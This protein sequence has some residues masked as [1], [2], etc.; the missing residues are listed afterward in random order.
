VTDAELLEHI[1]RLPHARANFKQ[2]VRE[3]GTKGEGRAELETALARLA[4]RGELIELRSGHFTA[5]SRSRE[6]AVGRVNMHRDGY[7]FLI[8]DRPI[9][10]IQGDVF[11]APETAEKA[12]HGDRV[13][14]RI[15]RIEANGRADGE[16]VKVLQR[17]HPTV[18]GEFRIGKR[19]QWVVPHDDRI[20]QWIE[21]PEGM[22]LPPSGATIDRIGVIPRQVRS[23]D[24]MIVNGIARIRR[25]RRAPV[26]RVI[27]VLG[28]P[29]DFGIDVEIII[30]KH[31]LPNRFPA[32]VDRAGAVDSG[33]HH[34]AADMK[35][36]AIF[37][38][39]RS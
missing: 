31:H 37:A 9:E 17:A 10:G 30:R 20:R 14:V 33:R 7:G 28:S 13:V 4:A 24:G 15:G 19:G 22:E 3:L 12:M 27:E 8:S 5:T 38:I 34:G 11:L 23:P 32:E 36:G 25:A 35:G 16:I 6:F 2:L 29:D 18:V 1:A 26:G 21:I 39:C